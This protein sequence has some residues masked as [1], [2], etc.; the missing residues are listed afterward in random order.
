MAKRLDQLFKPEKKRNTN[1]KGWVYSKKDY[2]Y[3]ATAEIRGIPHRKNVKSSYEKSEEN[4]RA[5]DKQL[6]SC[7][8]GN[9]RSMHK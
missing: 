2:H 5:R 7:F 6:N 1:K 4:K 9:V 8:K 3:T